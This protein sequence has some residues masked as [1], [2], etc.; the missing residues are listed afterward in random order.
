MVQS[1]DEKKG[2]YRKY[3]LVKADG[4]PV[5]PQGTYFVM[6]VDEFLI[7]CDLDRSHRLACRKALRT[8]AE[9]CGNPVL[10]KDILR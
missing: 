3:Q 8:Y 2:L 5:D 7:E 6:R 10:A 4:S 1:G 9:H